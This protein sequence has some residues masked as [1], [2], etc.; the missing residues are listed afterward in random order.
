MMSSLR[1][2][3]LSLSQLNIN[4]NEVL[5]IDC[6]PLEMRPAQF[7]AT[8]KLPPG[9]TFTGNLFLLDQKK[10]WK[11]AVEATTTFDQDWSKTQF[12]WSFA[13][14]PADTTKFWLESQ[15]GICGSMLISWVAGQWRNPWP[16]SLWPP[17]PNFW[18]LHWAFFAKIHKYSLIHVNLPWILLD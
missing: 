10:H 15:V 16:N 9:K 6:N 11:G 17:T 13:N 18:I 14:G 2:Y 8:L 4:G 3:V 12:R 7:N 1:I 5:Q